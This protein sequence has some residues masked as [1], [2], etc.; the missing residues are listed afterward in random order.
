MRVGDKVEITFGKRRGRN[1]TIIGRGKMASR[2]LVRCGTVSVEYPEVKLRKIQDSSEVSTKKKKKQ[3]S[4]K[5]PC[6]V[7]GK[8]V[9]KNEEI[10]V[11]DKYWHQDC[12]KCTSC[13]KRLTLITYKEYRNEPFCETCYGRTDNAAV[14]Y[15]PGRVG[16]YEK[17]RTSDVSPPRVPK[18]SPP[19]RRTQPPP[20]RTE[21]VRI[22][23]RRSLERRKKKATPMKKPPSWVTSRQVPK[24]KKKNVK[25]RAA[26]SRLKKKIPK[27]KMVNVYAKKSSSSRPKQHVKK[28]PKISGTSKWK[29]VHPKGVSYRERYLDNNSKT[30]YPKGPMPGEVVVATEFRNGWIRV[31]HS[32]TEMYW[33]PVEIKGVG[34][35][36]KQVT[37]GMSS[38]FGGGGSHRDASSSEEE[39]SEE[40][41]S[42]EE[43]ESP[44]PRAPP[45][46]EPTR[47]V[48]KRKKKKVTKRTNA[49]AAK[50]TAS[51]GSIMG[52]IFNAF[53][54]TSDEQK[55]NGAVW[56]CIYEDG[57]SWRRK[58]GDNSSKVT[59]IRGPECGDLIT[60]S[61]YRDGWIKSQSKGFWLPVS[62]SGIGKLFKLVKKSE[63]KK[64]KSS[65]WDEEEYGA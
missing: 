12:F 55:G 63:G 25:P 64:K 14:G 47:Q 33:L 62:I 24:Q 32:G 53:G 61:V 20:R 7:C 18:T 65:N 23:A 57:V 58:C 41:S 60:V 26:V 46:H 56:E 27:P 30:R 4:V 39:S 1:G 43:M 22:A 28:Q 10:F 15:G 35:C 29:C 11:M 6:Q 45:R 5:R 21:N 50:S 16:N 38:W 54:F 19:P 3:T 42:E 59:S 34:V 31:A 48:T 17:H 52:S 37:G 2:W 36:F 9:Y 44:P 49:S 40:E 51:S 8:A 13:K